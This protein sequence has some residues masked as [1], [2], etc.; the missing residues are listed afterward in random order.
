M[1]SMLEIELQIW[2]FTGCTI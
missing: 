2:S 1:F